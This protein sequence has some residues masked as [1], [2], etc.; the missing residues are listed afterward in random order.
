MQNNKTNVDAIK[1][2]NKRTHDPC[3]TFTEFL[4]LKV[5]DFLKYKIPYFTFKN[6]L[7]L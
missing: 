1:N 4:K 3:L 7:F 2:K 5:S 6:L